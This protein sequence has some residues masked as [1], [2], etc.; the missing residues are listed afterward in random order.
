M[1]APTVEIVGFFAGMAASYPLLGSLVPGLVTKYPSISI[2]PQSALFT[3]SVAAL[4]GWGTKASNGCTSG[5]MLCGLSR[6]SG[7]S[8]VATATFFTVALLTHHLVH[9]S[10]S[11]DA[12]PGNI[13]CYTPIFPSASAAFSLVLL[14]GS[15][16]FAARTI[17][18]FIADSTSSNTTNNKDS[19]EQNSAA[20]TATQFFS[21]LLFALGLQIS[22]MA[23]PAKVASFL[24]F[25]VMHAWD[26]SLALVVVFG[27]LPNLITIQR[28]GFTEPP[29][30]KK[31][32]E[33]PTKT[34]KDVDVKFV[35]GAAAFGVAGLGGDVFCVICGGDEAAGDTL[36]EAPCHRHWVCTDDVG[37][38]FERATQNESL[39][40]PKCCGQIFLLDLYEQYVPF[41]VQWAYQMKEQGEYSVLAKYRVYCANPSCSKFLS[42]ATHVKD[43]A[44]DLSYAICL[45]DA[46]GKLT[47][48]TC[49]ALLDGVKNHACEQNEDYKKFKQTAAEKGFQECPTCASTVE[50]KEA[51]NHI[52]CECG[53]E[54]CYIC[55]ESWPG[56][57]GCPHYGP[58]IYDEEGYNQD[59][60]HRDTGLNREGYTRQQAF[61]DADGD[62]E[63]DEEDED[64]DE[65]HFVLQHV[66][67]AMR[68]TFNALPHQDREAFL[69]N[70]QIQLFEERGITFDLPNEDERDGE[71]SDEENENMN[72]LDGD[73][74]LGDLN[75]RDEDGNDGDNEDQNSAGQDDGAQEDGQNNAP[76]PANTAIP[77]NVEDALNALG[78]TLEDLE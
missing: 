19:S 61:T 32:F 26:P 12:C 58:A 31:A 47:C 49:K 30:F 52:T 39:Y 1:T 67:A 71:E 74:H 76:L 27:V 15:V 42:P 23:H 54:F 29:A 65:Q 24:S 60:Y 75:D 44:T 77:G 18:H 55:G 35:A 6:L 57:H 73:N 4:I 50:L 28:K 7:R 17:P 78:G 46:C 62:D 41:D 25:P 5:H 11:T 51:C 68:A 22:G 53:A 21:G 69:L 40:P 37:S 13:P 33:L 48:T 16:I 20:R 70:L 72:D 56:M 66:D 3:T 64:P 10:L 8:A 36:L 34:I 63:D 38:F 43:P 2:S 14:A 59:G 45:D 9:P